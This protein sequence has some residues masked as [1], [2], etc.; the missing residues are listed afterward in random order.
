MLIGRHLSYRWLP[1]R[2]S[3]PFLRFILLVLKDKE[4]E[5]YIKVDNYMTDAYQALFALDNCAP[6]SM[7]YYMEDEPIPTIVDTIFYDADGRNTFLSIEHT[8]GVM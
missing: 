8:I 6:V 3:A 2:S 7:K 1:K 5:K 4:D